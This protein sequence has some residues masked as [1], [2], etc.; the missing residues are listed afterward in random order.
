MFALL[1][2]GCGK[3]AQVQYIVY[4]HFPHD[5]V[6]NFGVVHHAPQAITLAY[7]NIAANQ[8]HV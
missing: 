2:V 7:I 8:V 3:R 4:C 5:A 1:T 6:S